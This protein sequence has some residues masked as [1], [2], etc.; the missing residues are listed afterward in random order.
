MKSTFHNDNF[1]NHDEFFSIFCVLACG[2]GGA[3]ALYL[4]M[5]MLYLMG[6]IEVNSSL[7]FV[8]TDKDRDIVFTLR[9]IENA[10][11]PQNHKLV[12]KDLP[13]FSMAEVGKH[14]SRCYIY[15]LYIFFLFV[16]FQMYFGFVVKMAFG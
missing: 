14:A 8:I 7:F 1:K 12:R 13:T 5:C 11:L 10:E 6:S 4:C 3:I 16:Q 9:R 15:R 2:I